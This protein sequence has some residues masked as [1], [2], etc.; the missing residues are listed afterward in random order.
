MGGQ[1]A[2][3]RAL[4]HR[5]LLDCRSQDRVV[6]SES[7]AL[8]WELASKTQKIIALSYLTTISPVPLKFWVSDVLSLGALD[9]LNMLILRQIASHNRVKNYSR[10]SKQ[11]LINS[12]EAKGVKFDTANRLRIIEK[13]SRRD[14][15]N[16][17]FFGGTPA[18]N[19]HS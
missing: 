10:M 2:E 19:Q 17:N 14:A 1:V 16:F 8:A 7:F 5:L 3:I 4:H 13:S 18:T 6:Q 12:I 9:Q 15:F 11:E